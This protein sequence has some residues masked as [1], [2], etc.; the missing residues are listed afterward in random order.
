MKNIEGAIFDLDGTLIDSMGIWEKIDYEFLNKRNLK[1][2]CDLKDKIQSLTFE[3]G[4]NFFKKNFNLKES[5]KE[6]LNE[7]NSMVIKEYSLNIKLKNNAKDFLIKLKNK[8]IKLAIATSNTAELTKLVLK[9]NEILHFFD[10]ITTIS[11]VNR[12]KSFPDIYLL[13]AKKLNLS[14]EKCVVFEDILPAIKS[15]KAA[16]MK[17]IGVY[18]TCSKD[19]EDAI[20]KIADYYI[21]NYKELTL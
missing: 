16:N 11:E 15:A 8:G 3:E 2:P 12:N 10:S 4:A 5:P 19:K 7:W 13:C 18:D 20:K 14:P 17:T 9:N 21:Y 6:I 1:V